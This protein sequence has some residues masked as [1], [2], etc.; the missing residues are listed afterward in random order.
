MLSKY[1]DFDA[2]SYQKLCS[3][4][5]WSLN[6]DDLEPAID[7]L[8]DKANSEENGNLLFIK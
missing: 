7:S 2:H 4:V 5:V 6:I 3:E 1:E 8:E